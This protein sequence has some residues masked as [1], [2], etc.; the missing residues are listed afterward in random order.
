LLAQAIIIVPFVIVFILIVFVAVSQ[1]DGIVYFMQSGSLSAGAFLLNRLPW[2]VLIIVLSI[3]V[4]VGFF[5]FTNIFSL[6]VAVAV[7]ERRYFFGTIARSW[8]LVKPEFWR[9][10][11]V[12]TIWIFVTS[13]ISISSSGVFSLAMM[14]WTLL[15]D[16]MPIGVGII[17]SLFLMLIT[18]FIG[19]AV[20]ALI[21]MPLDGILQAL[22][23]FN[24]RIKS[25]GLDLEI[26]LEKLV[27][28]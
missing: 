18:N 25:E 3:A 11:G 7:F 6:S 27:N 21:T 16:F 24:R 15:S 2:V 26:R 23:Y 4:F 10:L 13:A 20:I 22:I 14:A 17:G 5:V 12:R 9:I 19:P 1:L 28:S 8:E